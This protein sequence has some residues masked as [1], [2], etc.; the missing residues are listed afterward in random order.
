MWRRDKLQEEEEDLKSPN[1]VTSSADG[2]NNSSDASEKWLVIQTFEQLQHSD[3]VGKLQ[4][5]HPC[6]YLVRRLWTKWPTLRGL[7]LVT[8]ARRAPFKII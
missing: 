5:C 7:I 4:R 2:N 8:V 1:K 6:H 3:L